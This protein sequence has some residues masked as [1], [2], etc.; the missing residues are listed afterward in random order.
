MPDI[1]LFG[2]TGYTGRLTA[3]ALARRGANFAIAG[4]NKS[5]LY[6][7]A[8][9]V[10]GPEVRIAAVGDVNALVEALED[11]KVLITTVGPFDELGDTAA[12]AALRA[13][14]NYIDST[15]EG[16]FIARLI[17]RDTEARDAG[18]CMAS[19]MGFDEI[20][21][22]VA[23]TLATEGMDK[24]DVVLTY[25]IPLE[26]SRGTIR[27][28]IGIV[29]KPGP[30]LENGHTVMI[31]PGKTTRWAPMPPPLGPKPSM[32]MPL[33]IGRLAPLHLDLSGLRIFVTAG[34][35]QRFGVRFALPVIGRVAGTRW[36][37][38]GLEKSLG[39]LPDGPDDDARAKARWTVLAEATS[40]SSWRN[41]AL[42]G[43]DHYG[44]TA[45]FLT[46][47]AMKMSEEGFS[48]PGFH[49]P[50]DAVGL[51]TLHK[52]LINDGVSIQ[53]YESHD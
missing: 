13:R 32:G 51:E 37:R 41:V 16:S 35:F 26:A 22:D 53:T 5:K 48:N 19:A 30:W 38:W 44:I 49:A 6:D 42:L 52:E 39:A 25:A 9:E 1:L 43:A 12:D 45:E 28:T 31:E 2:A 40:G 33:A 11:V 8:D 24:A 14:V 23:A 15:G 4:R 46:T 21:A 3:H 10:G 29:S 36:G 18:I 50:V 34:S 7:L 17:E 47:S 27:S 20:P